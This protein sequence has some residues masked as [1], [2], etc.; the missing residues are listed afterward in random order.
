MRATRVCAVRAVRMYVPV[1]VAGAGGAPTCAVSAAGDTAAT[2][3]EVRTAQRITEA[4]LTARASRKRQPSQSSPPGPVSPPAHAKAQG[5]RSRALNHEGAIVPDTVSADVQTAARLALSYG[6]SAFLTH[7]VHQRDAVCQRPGSP[8]WEWDP[9][10]MGDAGESEASAAAISSGT[11]AMLAH[12]S[13]I[14][15]IPRATAGIVE[16]QTAADKQWDALTDEAR[17]RWITST[18][19]G[20]R[21]L[22]HATR[23]AKSREAIRGQGCDSDSGA[24]LIPS[25]AAML[26]KYKSTIVQP[27]SPRVAALAPSPKQSILRTKLRLGADGSASCTPKPATASIAVS[28]MMHVASKNSTNRRHLRDRADAV[29]REERRKRWHRTLTQLLGGEAALMFVNNVKDLQ[30]PGTE[31]GEALTQGADARERGGIRPAAPAPTSSA[32]PATR[33]ATHEETAKGSAPVTFSDGLLT[34]CDGLGIRSPRRAY[35]LARVLPEVDSASASEA[36][37]LS[38]A[39]VRELAKRCSTEYDELRKD[40]VRTAQEAGFGSAEDAVRAFEREQLALAVT[41]VQA[42]LLMFQEDLPLL[43]SCVNAL[44]K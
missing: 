20:R 27:R 19:Q 14:P 39:K 18:P 43:K 31:V 17:V 24:R 29:R 4:V 33:D 30:L 42:K 21:A 13:P 44:S 7:L 10:M 9:L 40:A 35:V 16:L 11:P 36:L 23:L 32:A 38:L 3:S 34:L 37:P 2:S 15:Q 8:V 6:K 41:R 25:L 26:S 12:R 1:R 5:P 22:Q 28:G